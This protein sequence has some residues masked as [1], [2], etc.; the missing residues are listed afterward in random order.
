MGGENAESGELL[1][2]IQEVKESK[3]AAGAVKQKLQQLYTEISGSHQELISLRDKVQVNDAKEYVKTAGAEL[4][5]DVL[6]IAEK[7]RQLIAQKEGTPDLATLDQMKAGL[8]AKLEKQ[9]KEVKNFHA[10]K[11]IDDERLKAE[12]QYQELDLNKPSDRQIAERK[13]IIEGMDKQLAILP[14]TPG[15]QQY[16]ERIQLVPNINSLKSKCTADLATLALFKMDKSRLDEKTKQIPALTKLVTDYEKNPKAE[17]GAQIVAM[18]KAINLTGLGDEIF[19]G[20]LGTSDMGLDSRLYQ[21]L[22]QNEYSAA[23][24]TVEALIKRAEDKEKQQT[25]KGV[26]KLLAGFDSSEK[27]ILEPKWKEYQKL[28]PQKLTDDKTKI[29]QLTAM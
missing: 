4:S 5:A 10:I 17:T 22:W 3:E 7:G 29:D 21:N 14:Q 8:K 2:P 6:A 24:R 28:E 1:K 11:K 16:R 9:K 15:T 20:H 25:A 23:K 26:E 13:A 19:R 18:V 27:E 12:K